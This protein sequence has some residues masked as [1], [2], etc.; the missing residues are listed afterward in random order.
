[1][2]RDLHP[3]AWWLWALGCAVAA[4]RVTNPLI[5]VLMAAVATVVT[6]TCRGSSPQAANFRLYAWLAGFLLIVRLFFRLLFQGAGPTVLL[7]LPV[8]TLPKVLTGA[9]IL[10]PLSAEALLGGFATGAQLSLLML[11][12]GA[13]NTLASPKR[14]LAAMPGAIYELGTTVVVAVAV[15]P[16]LA[17]SVR[18][19]T[20]SRLLRDNTGAWRHLI[21]DVIMP[22]LSDALD[23]SLLL[24]GAMDSRGYGRAQPVPVAHRRATTVLLAIALTA[25]SFGA[26]AV[27]NPSSGPVGWTVLLLGV[28]VAAAAL[29]LAGRRVT[30]SRYRRDPW[31]W[32]EWVATGA[33][34]TTAAASVYLSASSPAIANP[35][36]SPLAWPGLA[37]PVLAMAIAGIAPAFVLAPTREVEQ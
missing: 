9:T 1:M 3:G 25:V 23:R 8:I 22:V 2:R 27:F 16:Q 28:F 12:V 21:R 33:G 20:R 15:F 24:A 19:V 26:F 29:R 32:P 14:L 6:L 36:I 37:W 5:L 34:L 31:A 35:A 30:R 13:A 11:C 10:G 4:T 17:E 7:N 18:R